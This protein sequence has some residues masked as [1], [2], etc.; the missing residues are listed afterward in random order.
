MI[1]PFSLPAQRSSRILDQFAL[2]RYSMSGGKGTDT[3]LSV[4]TRVMKTVTLVM[5]HKLHTP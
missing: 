1:V 3:H 2:S 5:I 4:G